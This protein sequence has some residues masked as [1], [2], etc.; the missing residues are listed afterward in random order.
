M[1]K[2]TKII[3]CRSVA[4]KFLFD[5]ISNKA[6]LKAIDSYIP[7]NMPE[8]DISLIKA[9]SFGVCR[10]YFKLEYITAGYIK[11]KTKLKIKIIIY[12]AIFQLFSMRQPAYAIINESVTSSKELNITW[13]SGVINAVLRTIS[14]NSDEINKQLEQAPEHARYGFPAWLYDQIK[15]NYTNE[16]LNILEQ[17]NQKADLYLRVDTQKNTSAEYLHKLESIGISGKANKEIHCAIQLDK[18]MDVTKLPGFQNG[19]ISVQDL[20]AQ[21]VGE[22]LPIKENDIVIDGCSAPGGKTLHLLQKHQNIKLLSIENNI[23]RIKKIQQN[24][25]RCQISNSRYSLIQ[26]DMTS[27]DQW[28]DDY[29][30]DIILLDAPCSATGVIRRQPDIKILRTQKEIDHIK[31]LQSK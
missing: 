7:K 22:I 2:K 3:S 1:Q 29:K 12:T 11:P 20:S 15:I 13:A 27:I 31:E 28:W 14:K 8:K 10:D 19:L 9:L 4:I 5:I 24:L 26:N 25:D 17:S 6:S 30:A 18:P 23:N 16:Y 21:R